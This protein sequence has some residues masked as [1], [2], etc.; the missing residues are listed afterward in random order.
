MGLTCLLL[1]F[2]NFVSMLFRSLDDLV[3]I[4]KSLSLRRSL[5]RH[6]ISILYYILYRNKLEDDRYD[7]ADSIVMLKDDDDQNEPFPSLIT[8]TIPY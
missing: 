7:S 8:T 2:H 6:H 3:L 1:P 4:L 5:F